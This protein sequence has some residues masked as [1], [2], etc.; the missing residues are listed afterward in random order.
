[1]NLIG[2]VDLVMWT[3]NGEGT[4]PFVLKRI[5]QVIPSAFV[6]KRIVVDDCSSD[7]TREIAKAF[8]WAV[9][10]N[11]GGGISNGAN[12]ALKQVESDFFI[13]FEQDL[14]LAYDWWQK[15]PRYL[16]DLT[17]AVASGIRFVDYPLSIRRIEEYSA[18]NYRKLEKEGLYSLYVKTLDNTIYRTEI[19]RRLGEF[20]MI[21]SSVGVDC[22]MSQ[23]VFL[24]GYQ[25]KVDYNV[26]SVHLRPGLKGELAHNYWYG[27]CSDELERA[28]F[29][30]NASTRGMLL[31]FLFSPARGI[32]IAIKKRAPEAIYIYPLMRLSYLRGLFDGR[33]RTVR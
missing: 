6:N 18:E 4:L 30:R 20:P 28:M 23:R 7:K 15:I 14:L 29:Q 10:F 3:K 8:G 11:E 2:K 19:I 1:L 27:T 31:R 24:G 21:P 26:V 16:S 13:S 12:T 32:E 33:R 5:A 25:W 17:V 22:A 9:V